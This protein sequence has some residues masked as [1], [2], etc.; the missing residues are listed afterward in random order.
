[1]WDQSFEFDHIPG[2]NAT[3]L[4]KVYD[5]GFDLAGET[6]IS[7]RNFIDQRYHS[8]WYTLPLTLKQQFFEKNAREYDARIRLGFQFTHSMSIILAK[9]LQKA[10]KHRM[11]LCNDIRAYR[12]AKTSYFFEYIKSLNNNI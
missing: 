5:E 6:S 3:I 1:M 4:V 9:Q 8:D 2:T 10:L 11:D 12:K 7:L